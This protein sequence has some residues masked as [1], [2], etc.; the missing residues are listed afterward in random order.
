[1]ISG[2][3]SGLT[4]FFLVACKIW[5]F[6]KFQNVNN[7][8]CKKMKIFLFI[9]IP[10]IVCVQSHNKPCYNSITKRVSRTWSCAPECDNVAYK[11][12][13]WRH[14]SSVSDFA[15]AVFYAQNVLSS[16]MGMATSLL[17]R[18]LLCCHSSEVPP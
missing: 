10:F 14:L 2:T 4:F 3:S 17:S 13:S 15:V 12:S 6:C 5:T 11:A 16:A 18:S 8:F 9:A 7:S 1:M